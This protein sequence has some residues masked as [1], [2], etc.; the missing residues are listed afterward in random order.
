MKVM[1][2]LFMMAVAVILGLYVGVVVCFIGGI[3][4]LINQIKSPSPVEAGAIAWGI[5]KIVFATVAGWFSAVVVFLPGLGLCAS[6]LKNKNVNLRKE[7]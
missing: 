5:A 4:D 1:L 3:V 6:G 7:R 2:G